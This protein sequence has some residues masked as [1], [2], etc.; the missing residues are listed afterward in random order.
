MRER[1]LRRLI[2]NRFDDFRMLMPDV[3]VHQLGREIEITLPVRIP[4]VHAFGFGH[5]DGIHLSLHGP[6]EEG[7][8]LVEIN[9]LLGR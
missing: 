9:D 1:Q 8:L 7:V 6:G 2:L 5:G 4:E 3:R